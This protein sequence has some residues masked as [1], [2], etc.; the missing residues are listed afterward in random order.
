MTLFRN[1]VSELGDYWPAFSDKMVETL[2]SSVPLLNTINSYMIENSGKKI[3]P[4]LSLLA[5]KTLGEVN[6]DTLKCAVVAEMIHTATLLHD[7]VA[8]NSPLRRGVPTVMS[9]YSPA[10]SVLTGDYWL[11]KALELL[12]EIRTDGVMAQFS[13]AVHQLAEGEMFQMEKASS[14]DTR[15]KDYYRIIEMK[16]ASLF[17]AAIKSSVMTVTSDM[18][19]VS[20]IYDYAW[21][22]GVAFQ[23]QDDIFDY[24]PKLNTGK[25][26]GTDILEHKITLPLIGALQNAGECERNELMEL[27]KNE[28]DPEALVRSVI[29][30][31]RSNHGIEYAKMRLEEHISSAVNALSVFEDSPGKRLLTEMAH[32]LST[33]ES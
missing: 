26:A 3:R 5:A 33:R 31:V 28:Q 30:F 12:T 9:L 15:E 25:K 27:F 21:N 18:N 14:M 20:A 8:D 29:G 24:S 2:D 7:D 17:I 16:T 32:Y 13:K 4:M 22:V 6:E 1:I 23:V 19:A 10:K 11:A